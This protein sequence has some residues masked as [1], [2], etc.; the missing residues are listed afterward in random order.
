[1]NSHDSR[2]RRVVNAPSPSHPSLRSLILDVECADD[3][4]VRWLW[5]ETLVGKFVSGYE[6][7]PL[8]LG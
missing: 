4:Q 1:M 8:H 2:A 5:T 6:L 7:V 3:Q